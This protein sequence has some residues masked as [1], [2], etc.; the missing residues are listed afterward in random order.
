MKQ[1]LISIGVIVAF[2]LLLVVAQVGMGKKSTTA[3][4]I[5][6][7]QPQV[8]TTANSANPDV[9]DKQDLAMDS[10]SESETNMDQAVT[11]PSGLKYIDLVEG[12]GATPEK[13]QTVVVHYTG[14]L[15]D[16][17]KFDSSRDRNRPF[18]FTI[19]VGQVIKGWDEG[20]SSMKVGGR[21]QLIIPPDLG[22]GARGAGGV[23]PPNA[24]LIFDVELLKIN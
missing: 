23:I 9:N 20:V 22:Y 12:E 15:E 21:R 18:S 13:G 3:G 17:S 4:E 6:N 1:I 11:T 8:V 5:T 19:G 7:T 16:G 14:T 10:S 2:G 24:T